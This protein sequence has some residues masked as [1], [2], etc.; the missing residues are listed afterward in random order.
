MSKDITEYVDSRPPPILYMD[1]RM[2]D[3]EGTFGYRGPIPNRGDYGFLT[4]RHTSDVEQFE[5]SR[6]GRIRTYGCRRILIGVQET[7][8]VYEYEISQ[9][10]EAVDVV[11]IDPSEHRGKW[12]THADT[13][14]IKGSL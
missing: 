14:L 5:L 9:F 10:N 6:M 12:H 13:V 3:V 8:L 1:E 11:T 7:G 4:F 2:K